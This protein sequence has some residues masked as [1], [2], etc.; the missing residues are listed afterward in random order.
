MYKSLL[1]CFLTN[2][3][4]TERCC[5]QPTGN[6]AL[7]MACSVGNVEAARALLMFGATL[8]LEDVRAVPVMT[9]LLLFVCGLLTCLFVW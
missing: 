3:A 4:S 8:D 6:S 9:V 2:L 7:M 5:L 1:V